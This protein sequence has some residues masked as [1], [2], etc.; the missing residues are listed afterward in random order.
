M[1][2]K[3]K[4]LLLSPKIWVLIPLSLHFIIKNLSFSQIILTVLCCSFFI[5]HTFP[6]SIRIFSFLSAPQSGLKPVK[7]IN[8]DI[9]EAKAL[10]SF[11]EEGYS[12]ILKTTNKSTFLSWPYD[13]RDSFYGYMSN[14]HKTQHRNFLKKSKIFVKQQLTVNINEQFTLFVHKDLISSSNM[15]PFSLP[16]EDSFTKKQSKKCWNDIDFKKTEESLLKLS[17]KS[18]IPFYKYYKYQ[19]MKKGGFKKVFERDEFYD[20]RKRKHK[21]STPLF[22]VFYHDNNLKAIFKEKN[23]NTSQFNNIWSAVSAYNFSQFFNLKMIPPTIIRKI[24]GRLGSLQLF[25][26][27]NIFFSCK[28]TEFLN[29]IN[30]EFALNIY[31]FYFLTGIQDLHCGN[32]FYLKKCSMLVFIDN[33]SMHIN[34]SKRKYFH[35]FF[36]RSYT[37]KTI[38]AEQDYKNA[39][40]EEA[41]E[42]KKD[43]IENLK[44]IYPAITPSQFKSI[45]RTISKYGDVL[46]LK[47]KDRLWIASKTSEWT[48]IY[49]KLLNNQDHYLPSSQFLKKLRQ[50]D[51]TTIRSLLVGDFKKNESIINGIYYRRNAI[52][53]EAKK[54]NKKGE[55]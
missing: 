6:K 2:F 11:L 29:I 54:T 48:R 17:I 35:Q 28:N 36:Q 10:I 30:R 1:G 40:F 43:S 12:S 5:K 51:K 20:F 21:T 3:I 47:Y 55:K 53:E 7:K 24:N 18:L 26:E 52:L 32:I 37:K 41:I 8:Q 25:I 31:N 46:Y 33:D 15:V 50:L 14:N 45:Q 34:L 9:R 4:K 38:L 16:Q 23:K 19:K 13:I 22:V 42:L 49:E 39:P 44:R 27:S